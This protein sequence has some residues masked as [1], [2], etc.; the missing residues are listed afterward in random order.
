MKR[1]EERI[2]IE[3]PGDRVYAY[4][5][6]FARHGE[7]GGFGL[8]VTKDG[9]GP[10]QVGTTFS[11]VAKQFG[12]Q[13]EHSTITEMD[14]PTTVRLGLH[15]RARRRPPPVRRRR[16]GCDDDAGQE[17]RVHARIVPREDHRLEDRQGI[18][19]GLRSDLANIKAR[20][21]QG[22]A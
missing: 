1:F 20:L 21:E 6:D 19:E 9:E 12:T 3:A 16:S 8:E 10:V 15:G 2:D 5:S 7:W 18:P 13:R 22:P 17:R 11:T 14:P 4:V